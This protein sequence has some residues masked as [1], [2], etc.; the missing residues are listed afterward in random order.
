MNGKYAFKKGTGVL[1]FVFFTCITFITLL[2]SGETRFKISPYLQGITSISNGYLELGPEIKKGHWTIRPLFRFP[3]TNKEESIVQLDRETGTWSSILDVELEIDITAETGP[4]N[5]F[6]LGTRAEWGIT[7]FTFCPEGRKENLQEKNKQSLTFEMK[8]MWYTTRGRVNAS[9]WA[10]QFRLRYGRIWEKGEEVGV[11]SP[12]ANGSFTIVYN[13]VIDPPASY[14]AL[15]MAF[16][17]PYYPGRDKFSYMPALYY[18][19]TGKQD[20]RSPFGNAGRLR[21]EAWIFYYPLIE[22][23]PNVRFGA[24]PFIGYRTHG[25]DGFD[26]LVYGGMIQMKIGTNFVDWL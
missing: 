4:I 15:S 16:A 2:H 8:G 1:F 14:P 10:P 23:K 25:D 5:H 21:V 3:I 22:G 24:A 26:R 13:L 7:G 12:S 11:V 20:S 9:Q 18:Q 19:L 17:L 6:H